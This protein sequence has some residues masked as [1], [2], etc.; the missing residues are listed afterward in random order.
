M[1]HRLA[2]IASTRDELLKGLTDYTRKREGSYFTSGKDTTEAQRM[3]K[4]E[5]EEA[6]ANRIL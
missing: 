2:V 1:P 4:A 6:A 5:I 3:N